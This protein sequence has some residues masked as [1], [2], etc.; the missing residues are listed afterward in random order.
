[1]LAR[2][3]TAIVEQER[4]RATAGAPS[5]MPVMSGSR[6]AKLLPAFL[7]LAFLCVPVLVSQAAVGDTVLVSRASGTAG[8][9][10]DGEAGIDVS[11]SSGGRFVAFESGAD[12]LSSGDNDAVQNV[13][14]RDTQDST[15]RLISRVTGPGAGGNGN[16]G[17]PAISPNGRYV[18]FESD[19]DNL[20]IRDNDAVRNVFVRDTQTATTTLVSRATGAGGV[21][22]SADAN[23]PS[24]SDTGAVSFD[25]AANNLS[26]EDA[27]GTRDVY[28]RDTLADSTTLVSRVTLGPGGD[29]DSY[30]SS[31]SDNGERVAFTSDADN[32]VPEDVDSVTNV[33]VYDIFS[34]FLSLASKTPGRF[35]AVG[36]DADSSEP[37][38]S[39]D[40][41]C[42]S[43]TS[44]AEN[45]DP[46]KSPTPAASDIFI[47][48]IQANTNKVAS[49]GDGASGAVADGS[50]F[51]SSINEPVVGEDVSTPCQ[52]R[53]VSFVS[54]AD[55]LS[56]EDGATFDVFARD[57]F[58]GVTQLVSRAT[59]TTGAAANGSS[60]AAA[61][62]ADG[63]F[64][65][66]VSEGD[67]LSTEDNDLFRNVYLRALTTGPPPPPPPGPD[68]GTN[69][70]GG[71]GTDQGMGE[72]PA[73]HV[74]A[75]HV[76]GDH[77]AAGHAAGSHSA[78]GHA[79]SHSEDS[80]QSGRVML[81]LSRQDVD[82]LFIYATLHEPGK[83]VVKASV[84]LR[85]G[86]SR[87]CRFKKVTRKLPLHK[88][89]KIRL[90]LSRRSL[91]SVKRALRSGQRLKAK[92]TATADY[93][94]G[95]RTRNRSRVSLR[96]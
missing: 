88:A 65:A 70:H 2:P 47:R 41:R 86:A 36:A 1:M 18:A 75:G 64:V 61:I 7:V 16:S 5:I 15:T 89:K 48:D 3:T 56:G 81:A 14:L 73:D 8:A 35:G 37:A 87:L 78:A 17:N 29:G 58:N 4:L 20:S 43:F 76:T 46:A 59:G 94:S 83:I 57:M 31:V 42:V 28:L 38:L 21:A 19:A 62:S 52:E 34:G 26:A 92:I 22:A 9:A 82:R 27:N 44:Y 6:I 66:F 33:Y 90:K 11:I 80:T 10:A 72:H 68:L 30:D 95:K 96:P 51:G 53:S 67:N 79:G 45:L 24:V 39:P 63:A 40:G 91:R 54:A 23:D 55:N 32:L 25:S 85:G 93:D 50:S 69:D 84:R 77:A 13:F 74:A 49:V 71:H 60:L 12:N